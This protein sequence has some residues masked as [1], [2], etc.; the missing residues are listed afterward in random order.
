MGPL[1]L[2]VYMVQIYHG[3]LKA[4][5][6]WDLE[7][8]GNEHLNGRKLFP[9]WCFFASHT[10]QP[11]AKDLLAP[12]KRFRSQFNLSKSGINIFI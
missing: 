9:T 10:Q 4:R 3:Y 8:K 12:V 1:Q 11:A 2:V 6:Q 7:K 5:M